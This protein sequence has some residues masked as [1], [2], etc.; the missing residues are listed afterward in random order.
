MKILAVNAGSS[1]LKF[2][3]YNMPNEEGIISGVFERIGIEGSFY[4]IK[5][6][7]DKISKEINLE[8]HEVAFKIL[9]DELLLYKVINSLDEIRGV[10]H[11]IVQG[12]SYF[13]S[14][15]LVNDDVLD[16]ITELSPLAPLHNPAALIGIRAAMHVIPNAKH[17]CVFDTSFHQTLSKDRF[18]YAL[19]YEWYTNYQVRKYGAHGTSHKYVSH[20][21]MEILKKDNS[22]II[23]C[24]LG[25]GASVSAVLD[26]KCVDTSMGLTPNAGLI[27]GTRCGD[28]DATII[29]YIMRK[30][31]LTA[32]EIDSI[33][34]KKSGF[35]GI[36]GVSSD[37]RDIT[38]GVENNDER[39]KLALDMFVDRVVDYIARYYFLLKGVDAIAFTAGIG[40]NS[41]TVRRKI[42]EKLNFLGVFLDEDKNNNNG[43][44]RVITTNDSTFPC[45]VVPTD[46]EL[47]IAK[48]TFD[49]I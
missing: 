26:G 31:N 12:G 15:V 39:C 49:L 34:N 35:L 7:G 40:E 25:N 32:D 19:P 11:R 3:L 22:K 16:K 46:E 29:P 28:I 38:S 30:T 41:K 23:V 8:D 5:Y 44:L 21:L 48:D 47:M 36:S 14:S 4:T 37:A 10:G 33:L 18:M 24:H 20:K 42:V 9:I 43:E 27:M 17:V 6:H 13:D 45:Y 1:S 2:K